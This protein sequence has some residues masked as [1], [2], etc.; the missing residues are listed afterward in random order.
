MVKTAPLP[1]KGKIKSWGDVDASLAEINRLQS[2]VDAETAAYNV[3]EQKKRAE[4]VKAH[5]P[6]LERIGELKESIEKFCRS[7]KDD[8]GVSKSVVMSNGVVKFSNTPP[9]VR[10][11]EG[12]NFKGAILLINASKKWKKVFL[13]V[14]TELNKQA[15]MKAF[16]LGE[17]TP[18]AK[19]SITNEELAEFGLE[20][21]SDEVFNLECKPAIS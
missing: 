20:V 16:K 9:S 2:T 6:T 18:G 1:T 7:H 8:F 19:D 14:K 21:D 11:I 13:R 10:E 5:E 12:F 17:Q 4:L 3:A 15:V